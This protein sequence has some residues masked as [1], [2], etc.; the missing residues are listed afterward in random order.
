MSDEK[1]HAYSTDTIHSFERDGDSI[2]NQVQLESGMIFKSAFQLNVEREW[3]D[4]DNDPDFQV[5]VSF[6]IGLDKQFFFSVKSFIFYYPSV[7]TYV[8]GAQKTVSLIMCPNMDTQIMLLCAMGN[9]LFN[10]HYKKKHSYTKGS[11][12]GT[13][14][15]LR[16]FAQLFV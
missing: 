6:V 7:L 5:K 14:P 3:K 9:I 4:K 8:L 11:K 2:K 15:L 16:L 13:K 1:K 10:T 12:E